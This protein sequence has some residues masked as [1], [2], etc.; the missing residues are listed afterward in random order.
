MHELHCTGNRYHPLPTS[1]GTWDVYLKN[2]YTHSL[3]DMVK[4]L[5]YMTVYMF[6]CVSICIPC[7]FGLTIGRCYLLM[8][9]QCFETLPCGSRKLPEYFIFADQRKFKIIIAVFLGYISTSSWPCGQDVNKLK[10]KSNSNLKTH[11]VRNKTV[12]YVI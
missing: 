5:Q 7:D 11:T 6:I 3:R 10:V 2:G 4:P 1:V 9:T 8:H 12:S